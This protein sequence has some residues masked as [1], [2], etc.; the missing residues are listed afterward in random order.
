MTQL[1]TIA[2]QLLAIDKTDPNIIG[3]ESYASDSRLVQIFTTANS[4]LRVGSYITTTTSPE[5]LLIIE[6]G[7]YYQLDISERDHLANIAALHYG[8]V[9]EMHES[10]K[11]R[12]LMTT[13]DR[14]RP[15]RTPPPTTRV[16]QATA[17][18]LQEA[19]NSHGDIFLGVEAQSG[20]QVRIQGAVD[21]NYTRGTGIFGKIGSG[22]SQSV[23]SLLQSAATS[24]A[25]I[26]ILDTEG[27]HQYLN[28]PASDPKIIQ[29]LQELGISP[30]GFE[31]FMILDLAGKSKA[32][33]AWPYHYDFALNFDDVEP[34][35][36]V[37]A[38]GMTDAQKMRFFEAYD[39]ARTVTQDAHTQYGGF[40]LKLLMDI[41][42]LI[43]VEHQG[44]THHPHVQQ[45][46]AL[47][48]ES[49]LSNLIRY[50]QTRIHGLSNNQGRSWRYLWSRLHR[51]Q[52][53]LLFQD[54]MQPPDW[55]SLLRPGQIVSINLRDIKR[56][57]GAF[58]D[59]VVNQLLQSII[60][61]QNSQFENLG[62]KDERLIPLVVALE[63][64]HLFLGANAKKERPTVFKTVTNMAVTGRKRRIGAVLITQHPNQLDDHLIESGINN[65]IVHKIGRR[66]LNSIKDQLGAVSEEQL[67]AILDLPP[68]EALVHYPDNHPL[69]ILTKMNP[70]Q[71]RIIKG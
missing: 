53:Q 38:T 5:Y 56:K 60:E 64:A 32:N 8:H 33:H 71:S 16:H 35:I 51:L 52:L 24:N 18:A 55:S 59:L 17:T 46:L 14:R 57:G 70:S 40:T 43:E 45:T 22:K 2:D 63:E 36:I 39:L 31:N 50:V 69:P 48:N 15:L 21:E 62:E 3:F 12:V 11:A 7:P 10:F 68:G 65:L 37:E 4:N 47:Q 34:H 41:V 58:V 44:Q 49:A 66:A 61:F 28:E 13:A 67:E 27:E 23:A 29:R 9:P 25:S 26:I 54:D 42:Q 19:F 1:V 20:F 6:S 30:K